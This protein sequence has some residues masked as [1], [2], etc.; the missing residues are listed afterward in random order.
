MQQE[1]SHTETRLPSLQE[2]RKHTSGAWELVQ[3][4]DEALQGS[5]SNTVLPTYGQTWAQTAAL[6]IE[7]WETDLAW[8]L[9]VHPQ[10]N[11][12]FLNTKTKPARPCEA[13]ACKW[14]RLGGTETPAENN[15]RPSQP[16]HSAPV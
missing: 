5:C 9:T 14:V 4:P 2:G 16:K 12:C 3:S 1:V 13:E 6:A 10:P 11:G 7:G 8:S 15:T